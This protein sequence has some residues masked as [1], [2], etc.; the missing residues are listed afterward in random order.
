M[1][2]SAGNI[3]S[4]LQA[5]FGAAQDSAIQGLELTKLANALFNIF[6]LYPVLSPLAAQAGSV[7][8]SVVAPA[9]TFLG[10]LQAAFP[11]AQDPAIQLGELTKLASGIEASLN[12]DAVASYPLLAGPTPLVGAITAVTP[13]Q[14]LTELQ[15]AFGAAQDPA[16]QLSALQPIATGVANGLLLCTAQVSVNTVTPPPLVTLP[17]VII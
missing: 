2:L 12:N 6:T 9:G 7:Q 11:A 14:A 15:N 3:K 5:A 17:G 13:A 4:R 10:T 16:I 1:A 8:G